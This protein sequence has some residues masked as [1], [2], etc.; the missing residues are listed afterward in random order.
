MK[1]DYQAWNDTLS[2]CP[3]LGLVSP[4]WL[5]KFKVQT[6]HSSMEQF[7]L[8]CLRVYTYMYIYIYIYTYIRLHNI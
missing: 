1:P 7:P 5:T 6:Y 2:V 3:T 8:A 4:P